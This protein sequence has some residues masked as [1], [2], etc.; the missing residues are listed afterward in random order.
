MRAFLRD[1]MLFDVLNSGRDFRC[2][3]MGDG[4]V[5]AWGES[6][7]GMNRTDLNSLEAGMGDVFA[8]V[9]RAV[10]RRQGPIVTRG[11]LWRGQF[12]EF[13][14]ETIFLPFSSKEQTVDNVLCVGS[15]TIRQQ[16]AVQTRDC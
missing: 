13:D 5:V 12:D 10:T 7:Q 14:Q 6:F 11:I 1:V 3:V 2:R 16:G 15:Y 9:L 8:R 4:A